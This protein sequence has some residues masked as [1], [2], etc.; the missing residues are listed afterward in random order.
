ML[1]CSTAVAACTTFLV[2][3]IM[4]EYVLSIFAVVPGS[5]FVPTYG[6]Q[7]CFFIWNGAFLLLEFFLVVGDK[8]KN[9]LPLLPR[10]LQTALVLL[11]VL[12]VAHWF[13]DEYVESRFFH[14]FVQGIPLFVKL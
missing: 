7:T 4:H 9:K 6:K 1:Q 12:P 14:D 3:G 5:K 11:M 10:P 13:I 2:S 8:K